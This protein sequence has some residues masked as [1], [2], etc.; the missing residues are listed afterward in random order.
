VLPVRDLQP[1]ELIERNGVEGLRSVLEREG[2]PRAVHEEERETDFATGSGMRA[3]S[4]NAR[5]CI[6]SSDMIA[7]ITPRLVIFAT[8]P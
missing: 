8:C 1:A 6:R 2:P 5:A 3:Q 7:R 4:R